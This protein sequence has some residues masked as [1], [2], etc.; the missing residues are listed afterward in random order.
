MEM[1]SFVLRRGKFASRIRCFPSA[2]GNS[3]LFPPVLQFFPSIPQKEV[4]AAC[5]RGRPPA[6]PPAG[7]R[8]PRYQGRPEALSWHLARVP[9]QPVITR[10][11]DFSHYP[12]G[13][14]D[15]AGEGWPICAG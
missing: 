3:L 4:Q 1:G 11:A 8:G 7:G 12:A 6:T 15:N 2:R 5:T 13:A 14:G 10:S 9:G